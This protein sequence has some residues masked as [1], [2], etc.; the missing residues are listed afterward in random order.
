ML[1]IE[2]VTI[3]RSQSDKIHPIITKADDLGDERSSFTT[4]PIGNGVKKEIISSWI[5]RHLFS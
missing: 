1:S 4:L 5:V 2:D 3:F